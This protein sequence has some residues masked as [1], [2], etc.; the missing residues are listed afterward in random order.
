MAR[1]QKGLN[2]RKRD[3]RATRR[4]ADTWD[5]IKFLILLGLIMGAIILS[6]PDL[7]FLSFGEVLSNFFAT[8]AGRVL[9]ILFGLGSSARSTI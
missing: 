4:K 1:K 3:I 9:A 2:T 5:R 8:T 6:S 7:G